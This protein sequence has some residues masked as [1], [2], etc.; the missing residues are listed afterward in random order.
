VSSS[1][2]S[3][4]SNLKL[5]NKY[6]IQS[7]NLF[8]VFYSLRAFQVAVA[9]KRQGVTKKHLLTRKAHLKIAKVELFTE[10]LNILDNLPE[11]KSHLYSDNIN[12]H[13]LC[14]I[15]VKTL[16]TNRYTEQWRLL[17]V[18]YF[19]EWTTKNE[20]FNLLNFKSFN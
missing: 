15:D 12:F 6:K 10:Y 4:Y 16:P 19:P 9:G 1:Q 14:Y 7:V 18:K 2:F 3:L 17:K 5:L 20:N 8:S 11:L 13:D